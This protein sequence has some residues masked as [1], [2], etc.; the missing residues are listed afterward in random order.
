ML[1]LMNLFI[2]NLQTS[3]P[4]QF[5][6][7][8]LGLAVNFHIMTSLVLFIF[9]PIFNFSLMHFQLNSS[10]CENSTPANKSYSSENNEIVWHMRT[11][12]CPLPL[13][14]IVELLGR[15]FHDQKIERVSYYTCRLSTICF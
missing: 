3:A 1:V 9:F 14:L 6:K 2:V 4:F 7:I 15:T 11:I 13:W 5:I 12:L 10:F 8:R